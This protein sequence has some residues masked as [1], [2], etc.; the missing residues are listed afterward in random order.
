MFIPTAEPGILT[1]I[2]TEEAEGE[3]ETHQVPVEGK[4]S[5]CSI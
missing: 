3:I 4:T 5:K 1:G 2:P